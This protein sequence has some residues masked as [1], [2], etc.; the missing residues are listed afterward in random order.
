M[1]FYCVKC[2]KKIKSKNTM[3]EKIKKPMLVSKCA[4]CDSKRSR[5]I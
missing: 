5:F 2:R 4:V 1:L 3:V